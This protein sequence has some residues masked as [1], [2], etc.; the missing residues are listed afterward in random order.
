[1]GEDLAVNR[2]VLRARPQR[3]TKVLLPKNY[4][5]ITQRELRP[6]QFRAVT[7]LLGSRICDSENFPLPPPFFSAGICLELVGI[8]EKF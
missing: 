5:R 4:Q 6:V 7:C 1:M 3:T 8:H 2:L